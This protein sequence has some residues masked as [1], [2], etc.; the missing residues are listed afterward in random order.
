MLSLLPHRNCNQRSIR[1]AT[2]LDVGPE[3]SRADFSPRSLR[4]PWVAHRQAMNCR[5]PRSVP[6]AAR[7]SWSSGHS[8]RF[9]ST[10]CARTWCAHP[11]MGISHLPPHPALQR[12]HQGCQ[13]PETPSVHLRLPEEPLRYGRTVRPLDTQQQND[14]AS[15]APRQQ[16]SGHLV[17]V[18]GHSDHAVHPVSPA[19]VTIGRETHGS[20]SA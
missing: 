1:E 12:F 19:G 2:L 13:F 20:T 11:H 6:Y 5:E 14:T 4:N 15:G 16:F 7:A 3:A 9:Q 17:V 10:V 8:P 18:A